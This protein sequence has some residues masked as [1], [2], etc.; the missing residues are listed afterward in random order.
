MKRF[1]ATLALLALAGTAG[2]AETAPVLSMRRLSLAAG[3]NHRW[4]PAGNPQWVTG[5]YGA[6]NLTPHLSLTGSVAYLHS[7]ERLEQQVG[8]RIRLWQGK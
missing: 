4:Q 3:V 7:G 1:L 2:A 8:V 6:Y 5:L